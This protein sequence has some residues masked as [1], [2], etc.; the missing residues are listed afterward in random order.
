MECCK[1]IPGLFKPVKDNTVNRGISVGIWLILIYTIVIVTIV[2]VTNAIVTIIPHTAG[3]LAFS[4]RHLS[5]SYLPVTRSF[6][7]GELHHSGESYE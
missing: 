3:L 4:G 5:F 2:I 6:I 1:S 7:N